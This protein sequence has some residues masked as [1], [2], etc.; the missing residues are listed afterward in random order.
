MLFSEPIFLFFFLPVLLAVYF[1]APHRYRN[2]ILTFSSL[3][4]YA[5]GEFHFLGWLLGSIAL[6]YWLAIALDKVRGTRYSLPLLVLG[7]TSDLLLLIIFKYADFL[8]ANV[9]TLLALVHRP[10][11]PLPG[12]LLP[13]GIS[14]FTF[15]KIS[16]K[17]D[18]YRG[19]AEVRRQPLDLLLY[20]LLFPQLIA[21]P[22]IRYHDIADQIIKREVNW[23][24][25]AEGVRRFILGLGKKMIIANTVALPADKIFATPEQDL[26]TGLAWLGV[27]CYTLQ[28]YFDFSGYSDMAIGLGKMFGFHFLENFHYP[29]SASSITDFWRRWHISLSRWFR[30]YL[31]IPLGGNRGSSLRTYFNLITVFLLCGLWHGASWNFV[32]WGLFHG[33]FLVL[34]RLGWGS[35]LTRLPRVLAHVY[36]LLTVMVG[37]VLFRTETLSQAAAFLKAMIGIGWT[38]EAGLLYQT[39]LYLNAELLIAIFLG[40]LGSLP[41]FPALR[42]AVNA[43]SGNPAKPAPASLVA[44]FMFTEVLFLMTVFLYSLMLMAAGTYSPFIY[45]RF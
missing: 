5:A 1:A 33:C 43:L 6:N 27:V 17:I 28:I 32:A 19:V 16:Y 24:V 29:Y 23:S 31:Y 34:E 40:L 25:F 36:T 15:H 21:G 44:G 22:I 12:L 45:Y 3:I 20:I 2:F 13:L 14:F 18:V 11:L 30:D 9:N 39:S 41:F 42:R 38:Q 26:T 8:V 10:A 7:I 4:F 37:W 35:L